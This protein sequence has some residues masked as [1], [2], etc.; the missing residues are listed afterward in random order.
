MAPR[1]WIHGLSDIG[2]ATGEGP[3][4]MLPIQVLTVQRAVSYSRT[5]LARQNISIPDLGALD[6]HWGANT[7]A[8]LLRWM[9]VEFIPTEQ[10]RVNAS[11]NATEIQ[12]TAPVA[13]RLTELAEQWSLW[14]RDVLRSRQYDAE[15]AEAQ[16]GAPPPVVIGP[17][18]DP[19]AIQ[20]QD[21]QRSRTWLWILLG[22]GAV[23]AAGLAYWYFRG[24]KRG[25]R[26]FRG[27]EG[28]DE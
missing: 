5:L 24:R 15:H 3:I 19:V 9:E 7:R 23:G 8:A 25:R 21:E 1:G 12:L 18:L 27:V 16:P 14:Q 13:Q 11:E 17:E 26:H 20:A 28:A 22:V 10:V 2:F 6:G 4:T